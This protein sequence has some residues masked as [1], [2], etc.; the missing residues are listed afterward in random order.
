MKAV[1]I[2]VYDRGISIPA[3]YVVV[4]AGGGAPARNIL[5]RT[6]TEEC[7][8]ASDKWPENSRTMRVAHEFLNTI[9]RTVQDGDV[10]DVGYI[11]G[12]TTTPKGNQ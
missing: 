3:I 9:S 2:E 10:I 1:A 11:L 7:R 4:H 5:M 6:D 8:F 12:E